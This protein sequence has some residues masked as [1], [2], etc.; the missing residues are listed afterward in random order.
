MTHVHDPR[1]GLTQRLLYD[2][3]GFLV[4]VESSS[5]NGGSQRVLVATDQVGN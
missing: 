1:A 5:P 2:D 3:K 4:A